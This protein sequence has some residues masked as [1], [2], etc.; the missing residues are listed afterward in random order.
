MAQLAASKLIASID[1][2]DDEA[3]TAIMLNPVLIK[4]KSTRAIQ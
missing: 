4:R 1:G 3:H 2:R